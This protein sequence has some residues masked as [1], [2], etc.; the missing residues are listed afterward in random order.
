MRFGIAAIVLSIV[1]GGCSAY[2]DSPPSRP[3]K[4]HSAVREDLAY[5]DKYLNIEIQGEWL[6]GIMR[7][8]AL[9][10][11]ATNSGRRSVTACLG[12]NTRYLVA[13]GYPYFSRW[14]LTMTITDHPGCARDRSHGDYFFTIGPGESFQ[15]SEYFELP[16]SFQ[17]NTKGQATIQ[18]MKP[19]SCTRYGCFRVT[20]VVETK[21]AVSVE[22][23]ATARSPGKNSS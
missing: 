20:K 10:L 7:V 15:W 21:E 8:F 13:S 5:F 11:K 12:E 6:G 19:D 9:H 17:G 3:P 16:H 2:R 22:P 23:G 4:E 14:P 1:L 18:L